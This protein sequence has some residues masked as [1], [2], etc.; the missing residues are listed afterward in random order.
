MLLG[1]TSQNLPIQEAQFLPYLLAADLA[2][3]QN[4]AAVV[5]EL[6]RVHQP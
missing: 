6:D 4:P 1:Q 3:K 5:Q 2:G